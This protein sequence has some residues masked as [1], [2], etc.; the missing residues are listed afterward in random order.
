MAESNSPPTLRSIGGNLV[1]CENGDILDGDMPDKIVKVSDTVH[2][3]YYGSRIFQLS[4]DYDRATRTKSNIKLEEI[5]E[6]E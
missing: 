5:T 4:Y 1:K 2:R 6:E 3:F